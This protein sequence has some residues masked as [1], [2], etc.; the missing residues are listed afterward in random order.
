MSEITNLIVTSEPN[1]SEKDALQ[2]YVKG[3][4]PLLLGLDG[5]IVKRSMI[6]DTINGK[7]NF[8]FILIMDFPSKKALKSMFLSEE[9]KKLIPIRDKCF[10]LVNIHFADDM[11]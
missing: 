4:M 1:F 11:K 7:Q 2:E 6:T 3:V 8:L 10:N 5:K 9:Y